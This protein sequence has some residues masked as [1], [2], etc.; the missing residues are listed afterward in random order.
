MIRAQTAIEWR[1]LHKMDSKLAVTRTPLNELPLVRLNL[2]LPLLFDLER[3]GIDVDAG[4]SELG[5]SVAD[6]RDS[7]RFVPAPTMYRLV[8]KLAELS[9]DPWFGVH[10]GELW[11]LGIGHLWLRL[12]PRRTRLGIS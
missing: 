3:L 9:G 5:L 4:L 2:A 8:E 6:I 10:A 7:D 11:T 12:W 1:Q